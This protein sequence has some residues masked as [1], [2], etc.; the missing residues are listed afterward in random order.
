MVARKIYLKHTPTYGERTSITPII[1]IYLY[2][3]LTVGTNHLDLSF[4]INKN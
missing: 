4:L 3:L 1:Q 2:K